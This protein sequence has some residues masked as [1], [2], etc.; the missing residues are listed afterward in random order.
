M[1]KTHWIFTAIIGGLAAA[2]LHASVLT[3]TP[4]SA[5]LFYLAPLPLFIVGFS[6]GW[7]TAAIS[8]AVGGGVLAG[9]SG[10]KAGLFFLIASAAGP[11]IL[12]RLAL[13]HRPATAGGSEGEAAHGGVEWY[14]EGRLLLWAAVLAGALLTLVILLIG[15]DAESFRAALK[16]LSAKFAEPLLKDMPAQQRPGFA[17]LVDFLAVLAPVASAAALLV[18]LMANMLLASRLLK[19]FGMSLR[20]W[21]PFSSLAFPRLAGVALAGAGALSLMPGTAGLIGSVYAAPLCTA[22]AILGLAVIH[23]LLLNHSARVPLLA[24]LYAVL[25]LLS[26]IVMV[27]LIALGVAELGFNLRARSRPL[28]PVNRNS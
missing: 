9:L 11:V 15:P 20:P 24:G 19:T 5:L 14:P 10:G 22:F 12:T 21:A 23:Y 18:A 4:L 1:K 16:E 6:G 25:I 28:P 2:L 13:I 7:V 26:W 27:P 17:Q 3:L 8:A